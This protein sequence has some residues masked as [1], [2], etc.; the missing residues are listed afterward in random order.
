MSGR[1]AVGWGGLLATWAVAG[2]LAAGDVALWTVDSMSRVFREQP[3][4]P[5]VEPTLKAARGEWEAFQVVV[6]GAPEAVQAVRLEAVGARQVEGE[7]V[8]PVPQLL[9]EHY[10]RVTESS[11]QT[12]LPAGDYPDALVPLG[13]PLAA[14]PEVAWV[15]QPFWVDVKVPYGSPPGRYEGRVTARFA[16][17]R[18]ES[19]GYA[20]EVWPFD[21]PVVP[22]MKSSFWLS[23]R[24]VAE[25]HG[26]D[27]NAG[28]PHPHLV[29]LLEAYE[30]LLAEHRL[31]IDQIRA[32]YPD[33]AS[34]A[35]DADQAE[36]ALR[37]HL[38]H[39]HA[40]SIA[41]PI[42]PQWPFAEPLGRDREAV[43][44]YLAQ[45]M[46][47]LHRFGCGER[48]YLALGDLDEPNDAAAYEL[49]RRW[50]SLV[51]EAEQRHGVRL[52]LMITEQPEPDRAT[53]GSLVGAVDIWVPHFSAVYQDLEDPAGKREIARRLA[54]GEEVWTYAALVQLSESWKER[55][56]F[57]KVVSEGHPPVWMIDYP[58]INHRILPWL[59]GLHGLTGLTYWDV[60]HY[61][62]GCDPWRDA[63]TF[64]QGEETF[65]GDG[66]YV[67]PAT[68][69]QQGRDQPVASMRLKWLRDAADDFD[70]LA[71]ARE[72]IGE[73]RVRELT[74]TFAR[75]FGDWQD[76]VPALLRAREVLGHHIAARSSAGVGQRN[77]QTS[78]AP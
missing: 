71:L 43:Q 36:R 34:G 52:P 77:P 2:T 14:L 8:L 46:R 38:L 47:L 67:Y 39:R 30:G 73:A 62:E 57:P 21:L 59:M 13:F 3:A 22:K 17:G 4:R 1:R 9:R 49:V 5:R 44:A 61:P 11:P 60:L 64:R 19:V 55:H 20:V 70:Y 40:A 18:S 69:R 75:G 54:A 76:D 48:G 50:G 56:G 41:L 12:S 33:A 32:S 7:A 78:Q 42:F 15:N 45:W 23:W 65:N 16:N 72:A 25:V 29:P 31:S 24:R 28:E 6:S 58:P 53:W 37:R 27:R 66:F 63:G 10:V 26:F 35:L 68:R 51:N 74:A